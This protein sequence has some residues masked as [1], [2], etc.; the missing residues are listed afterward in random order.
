M[1]VTL[2]WREAAC[3]FIKLLDQDCLEKGKRKKERKKE[4]PNNLFLLVY[5][6]IQDVPNSQSIPDGYISTWITAVTLQTQV[7]FLTI[8]KHPK[9]KSYPQ[10]A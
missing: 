4:T 7:A 8:L 5:E 1:F 2:P 9:I 3:T 6:L 10:P